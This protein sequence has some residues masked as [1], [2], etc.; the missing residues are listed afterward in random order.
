MPGLPLWW[1]RGPEF[2]RD[3]GPSLLGHLAGEASLTELAKRSVGD[4]TSGDVVDADSRRGRVAVRMV[5]AAMDLPGAVVES[6][7]AVVHVVSFHSAG[8]IPDRRIIGYFPPLVQHSL[9]FFPL[10][11]VLLFS[12]ILP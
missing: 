7:E 3:L 6:W 5:L 4:L 2:V 10:F 11:F 12:E 9:C 8:I 1:S